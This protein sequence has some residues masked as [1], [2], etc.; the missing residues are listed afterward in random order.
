MRPG[1]SKAI[2]SHLA[3]FSVDTHK[4]TLLPMAL[5]SIFII[6]LIVAASA[7]DLTDYGV[8]PYYGQAF[9][10]SI[11]R[12]YF[13]RP[14]QVLWAN[15]RHLGR[16]RGWRAMTCDG[17]AHSKMEPLCV[18][19]SF[20]PFAIWFALS[21]NSINFLLIITIRKISDIRPPK[22]EISHKQIALL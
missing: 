21:I 10:R 7:Q 3:H 15:M 1:A 20:L 2:A 17:C 13:V 22:K 12:M 11:D 8:N 16:R 18:S 9:K 4:R 14:G 6:A 19:P 5:R